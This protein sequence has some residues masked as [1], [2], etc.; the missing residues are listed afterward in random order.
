MLRFAIVN[1]WNNP[2]SGWWDD[3]TTG[4]K[5]IDDGYSPKNIE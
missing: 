5:G 3:I 2:A 1:I 4:Q